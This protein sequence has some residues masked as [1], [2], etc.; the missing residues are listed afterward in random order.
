MISP[1]TTTMPVLAKTF[2]GNSAV[3]S[4]GKMGV[5]NRIGY[6]IAKFVGMTL[7]NRFGSK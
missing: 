1:A 4:P 3:G 6:L 7:R 2:T 5:E